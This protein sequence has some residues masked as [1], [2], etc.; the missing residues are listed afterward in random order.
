MPRKP[1]LTARKCSSSHRGQAG[2]AQQRMSVANRDKS[3]SGKVADP[4]QRM[5]V[6][7]RMQLEKR[8]AEHIV[9]GKPQ[10][11]D[12]HAAAI[13]LGSAD[14]DFLEEQAKG[15]VHRAGINAQ[16]VQEAFAAKDIVVWVWLKRNKHTPI[17]FGRVLAVLVWRK[18]GD[19]DAEILLARTAPEHV[20]KRLVQQLVMELLDTQCVRCALHASSKAVSYWKKHHFTAVKKG[21]CKWAKGRMFDPNVTG[22][23]VMERARGSI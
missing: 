6:A 23:L 21:G 13:N 12:Y 19:R 10:E 7:N 5:S 18:V 17:K 3:K 20:G 2:S 9:C 15:V 16:C 11:A 4:N 1:R 14:S 8:A 22:G